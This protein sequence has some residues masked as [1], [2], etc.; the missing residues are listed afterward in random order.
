LVSRLPESPGSEDI[1][2]ESLKLPNKKKIPIR[3]KINR[4]GLW[5]IVLS[6]YDQELTRSKENSAVFHVL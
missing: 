4:Q 6:F 5:V 1:W 3:R 2:A